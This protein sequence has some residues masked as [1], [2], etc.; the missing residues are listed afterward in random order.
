[1]LKDTGDKLSAGERADLES[2]MA[3]LKKAIEAND[4]A[5]MNAGM[6]RLVAAQ[7]KAAETIYKQQA[8][9]GG[10][11]GEPGAAPG[12]DTGGAST[13]GSDKDGDVID[14]EVV[15]DKK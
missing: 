9:P 4:T 13:G 12:G 10:G 3:D 1:M 8:T 14:A 5:G 7:H 6:D 15:D 2:A 11:A